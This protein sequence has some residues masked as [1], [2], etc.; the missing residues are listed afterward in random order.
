MKVLS[1]DPERK[2]IALTMKLGEDA[3]LR[4]P[5]DIEK[6]AA[7]GSGKRSAPE[8]ASNPRPERRD[9]RRGNER[10]GVDQRP[11]RRPSQEGKR[12]QGDGLDM[13]ALLKKWS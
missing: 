7:G 5:V 9:D 13:S 8:R 11:E 4:R 2:R 1:V 12:R 6:Q 10:S 3:A